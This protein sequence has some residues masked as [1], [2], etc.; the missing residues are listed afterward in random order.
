MLT[1]FGKGSSYK[2]GLHACRFL[3]RTNFLWL[4]WITQNPSFVKTK[5]KIE[6]L[7]QTSHGTQIKSTVLIVCQIY[8]LSLEH[9]QFTLFI[10]ALSSDF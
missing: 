6:E 7:Q 8:F 1:W 2:L 5:S 3:I 10:G 9:Y 4:K